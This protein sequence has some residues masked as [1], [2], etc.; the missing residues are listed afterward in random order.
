MALLVSPVAE[1]A[2]RPVAGPHVAGPAL[3]EPAVAGPAVAGPPVAGPTVRRAAPVGIPASLLAETPA[4]ETI[5]F[6]IL[7]AGCAGLSLCLALVEAGVTASILLI[8]QRTEFVDDRTWCWWDVE[9]TPFTSLAFAHWETCEVRSAGARATATSARHPYLCLSAA[10]FYEDALRRI[11]AYPNVSLQLGTRIDHYEIGR[12]ET[13]VIA[14]AHTWRAKNLIDGRGIAPDSS[15]ISQIKANSTWL[16]QQFV[17]QRVRSSRPVFDTTQCMLMDFAVSQKRGLRFM[18]VLPFSPTE[19]LVENVY[20]STADI[21]V[22]EHRG[23]IDAHIERR[24][25]LKRHEYVIDGEESGYIPMTD[26]AFSN[27]IGDRTYAI[28]MRG[29]STRPSTG[30]TFLGI[31]RET[32]ALAGVL[33]DVAAGVAAGGGAAGGIAAGGIAAGGIAAGGI[34]AGSIAA[35]SIAASGATAGGIAAPQ[36]PAYSLRLAILDS[37]FLRFLADHPRE[38]PAV[39]SRMFRTDPEALIRFLSESSSIRD[40]LRLVLALPKRRFLGVAVQTLPGMLRK[41]VHRARRR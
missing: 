13:L 40:E 11:A 7:G 22:S 4:T 32:K 8:D 3:A 38:S 33:A 12:D 10:D 31:Q 18:Y 21:S 29:G 27:R 28:G 35:G 5:E 16:A 2:V 23:E 36:P 37:I 25:G 6:V 20:L 19:A 9:P 14:E 30:Y 39:F 34:A 26:H 41:I 24:Y 17:G 15:I 1:T